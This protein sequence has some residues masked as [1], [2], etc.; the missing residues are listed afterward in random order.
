MSATGEGRDSDG[1]CAICLYG[2]QSQKQG[3][4]IQPFCIP[5]KIPDAS[6]ELK[7]GRHKNKVKFKKGKWNHMFLKTDPKAAKAENILTARE[8]QVF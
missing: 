5:S 6:A 7:D 4:G 8:R 1:T 3:S 2:L